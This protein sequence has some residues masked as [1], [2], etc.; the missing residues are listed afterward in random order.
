MKK[1]SRRYFLKMLGLSPLIAKVK[2]DILTEMLDTPSTIE[3]LNID[4]ETGD[5]AQYDS[6]EVVAWLPSP[7]FISGGASTRKAPTQSIWEG[8]NFDNAI[9]WMCPVCNQ[10]NPY[11]RD[12]CSH[13]GL[14]R[15]D[16][17]TKTIWS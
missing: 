14:S 13:C 12:I 10:R 1:F 9:E 11:L 4:H 3:L 7:Y 6:D 2:P 8:G 17:T 16:N 15:M 5:L